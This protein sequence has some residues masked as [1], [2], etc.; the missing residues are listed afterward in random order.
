VRAV[1]AKPLVQPTSKMVYDEFLNDFCFTWVAHF[2]GH[3]ND[4]LVAAMGFFSHD[5]EPLRAAAVV[6]AASILR[7]IPPADMGRAHVDQL[8]NALMATLSPAK[9][10]SAV[11]RAKAA[12]ALGYLREL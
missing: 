4:L 11:V 6:L 12:R 8:C 5:R 10:K 7:H 3:V 1:F 2:G 9:E